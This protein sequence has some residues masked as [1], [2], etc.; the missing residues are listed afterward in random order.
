MC[1]KQGNTI[2]Y[3]LTQPTP[4]IFQISKINRKKVSSS[5]GEGELI[6]LSNSNL[7]FQTTLQLPTDNNIELSFTFFIGFIEM[8]L[9]GTVLLKKELSNSYL[10][11]VEISSDNRVSEIIYHLKNY[12]RMSIG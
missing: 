5:K 1:N 12:E 11:N 9:T 10:Y 3:K 6:D 4:I 2:T 8:T 7:T